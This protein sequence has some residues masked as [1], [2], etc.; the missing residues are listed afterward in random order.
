MILNEII[1]SLENIAPLSLQESYDNSGLLIGDRNAKINKAL[2]SLDITEKVVDEAL[3]KECNLIIAH[4]PLI[5]KGLKSLTG[6]N[7]IEI[8]VNKTIK[9]NIAVYAIH[10]NL[11]N[12][13]GGINSILSQKLGLINTKILLPK[14]GMLRKLV[15]FCPENEADK[16]RNAL[17]SAGAG[18]IGNYDH[19]SY[20]VS[21]NGS[22]RG[23]EG[24]NPFVGEK[25]KTHFEEEVRI[26]TI[27]PVYLENQILDA[28]SEAHPY[29]EVAYDLYSLENINSNIGA[30]MIGELSEERDEKAFLM[31]I[32]N[33]TGSVCI[34]HSDLRNKKIKKVAV[35]GG[36]GSFLISK[37]IQ[38]GADIFITG[39]VKYH[40][41]FEAENKII[42]ADIGHFE[43]EQ[44][45]KE[46]IYSILIK[47]F[48]TFA[49]L[50]SKI[51]TNSVNYL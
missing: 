44:Y 8:I 30:G 23:L 33:R 24:S 47:K 22:F 45:A 10:T 51:N 39:D 28:L 7:S 17:F 4:H 21:G 2:I 9:N 6:K 41:F 35:C 29:E 38:A 48:P 20:N 37:A 19:C 49:V 1:K 40:E 5:F 13:I 43:S 46:L 15:T 18:H 31:D 3:E 12:I 14:S 25:G 26:E 27:Y 42:I 34:R 32:K 16:V 11:D 36:S 50:I